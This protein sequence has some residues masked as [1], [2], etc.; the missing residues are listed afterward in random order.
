M[1]NSEPRGYRRTRL[2]SYM[3]RVACRYAI[4]VLCV[5]ERQGYVVTERGT[6]GQHLELTVSVSRYVR[7]EA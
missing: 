1:G 3:E 7:A 4:F 2:Y 5:P 6:K